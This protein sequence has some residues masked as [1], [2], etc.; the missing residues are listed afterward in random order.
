MSFALEEK[1][2]NYLTI[3]LIIQP[4]LENA[5]YYGMEAM[6]GD[7]EI[8]VQGY[9]KDGDILIDIIDNG[10]GMPPEQVEHLLKE[11]SS[12]RKRGSGIGL[13]N[14]D[15]R[16]KLY[17]GESYGLRIKSEPDVGTK[18]TIHLPMKLEVDSH[19]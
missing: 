10:I 3:K 17:F 13:R 19:E 11:G 4:I 2:K 5:I 12:K 14:V 18:V 9:E 1:L 16:I 8:L 15:Q 6:D 7:G